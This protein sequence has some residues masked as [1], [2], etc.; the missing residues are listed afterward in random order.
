M[1]RSKRLKSR[2]D[3]AKELFESGKAP[4]VFVSGGLGHEGHE[5]ALVMRRYLVDQNI[6]ESAIIVDKDGYN[7]YKT[8]S[9]VATFMSESD[10]FTA[11]L[12]TQYYHIAR[13][14]MAFR[15]S[16]VTSLYHA[17]AKMGPE[18]REPFSLAR[19][20]FAFYYYLMRRYEKVPGRAS[21][22]T[23]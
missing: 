23:S 6:P 9:N 18:L 15:L 4:I 19:E 16:G 5:E 17:R 11:I 2:L 10:L 12:V 1:A 7:T 21:E 3:R 13:A 22:A 8:A 20:F 14:R